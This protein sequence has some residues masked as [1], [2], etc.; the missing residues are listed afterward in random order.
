M[1]TLVVYLTHKTKSEILNYEKF[2][3]DLE[4]IKIFA[5]IYFYTVN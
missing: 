4:Q 2:N 5:N 3:P 1:K